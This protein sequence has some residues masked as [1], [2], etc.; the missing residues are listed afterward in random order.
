M[1]PHT[2]GSS[3]NLVHLSKFLA[4][5]LRHKP[6]AARTTLDQEGWADVN[7]LIQGCRSAGHMLDRAAL[8]RI[9][10]EDAKGRYT[11]SENG[12]RIRANQG[13]SVAV[14]LGLAVVRP[15]EMLFHGTTRAVLPWIRQDGL[16]K[17]ARHHVHLSTDIPTAHAVGSRR[18][19]TVVLPI[20]A[21]A[22]HVDGYAFYRSANGVWLTNAVPPAYIRFDMAM[23]ACTRNSAGLWNRTVLQRDDLLLPTKTFSAPLREPRRGR[24]VEAGPKKALPPPPPRADSDHCAS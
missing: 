14:D 11:F 5:V 18:G 23:D 12:Q 9:V 4:L 3:H 16:T 1:K 7:K 22:M 21:G 24:N 8:E 6:E 17:Q 2:E 19:R 20:C 15:P 10:R 13:H